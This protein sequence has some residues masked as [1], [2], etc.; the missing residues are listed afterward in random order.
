MTIILTIFVL[1][2]ILPLLYGSFVE[3]GKS[4]YDD[5]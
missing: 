2:V 5:D 1:I 4:Y 3:K